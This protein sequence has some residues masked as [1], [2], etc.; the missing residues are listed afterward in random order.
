MRPRLPVGAVAVLVAVAAGI[1]GAAGSVQGRVITDLGTAGGSS[2]KAVA[3][4]PE[5]P[6]VR[7]GAVEPKDAPVRSPGSLVEVGVTSRSALAGSQFRAAAISFT[8]SVV[9]IRDMALLSPPSP[10]PSGITYR[11]DFNEFVISDGEVEETVSGITHFSGSNIW[12]LRLDGTIIRTTNISR[13]APTAVSMTNEPTGMAWNPANGHYYV[14][15]DDAQRVYDLNPGADQQIGTSDDSF[16]SFGTATTGNGDPEGVTIDSASNWVVVSDGVNAEVYIYTLSGTPVSHFDVAQYGI[17]DPESVEFNAANGT[18]FVLGGDKTP[19]IVETT[20]AGAL[21]Q[22]IDISSANVQAPAGLAYAPASNGSGL[23]RFYVVAR[24]VDN[25]SDP[26]IVD[27]KLFELTAVTQ[28]APG[29]L[30]EVH[31]TFTGATS[32]VFDWRGFAA[33]IRYGL[34]SG[35]GSSATASDPSPVPFSSGGPF[36]EVS[37]TG[38]APGTTYHYSIGGG[39]D[40]TF[41]TV[42]TGGFRFDV[43]GDVGSSVMT[44]RAPIVAGEVAADNPAFV[45]VP[46]DISYANSVGQASVDAHFNEVMAWSRSAAYMPAWGNHEWDTPALDDL[47]NYTG[48]FA[49]PNAQ[50]ATGAPAAGCCGE[51][52]SWFDA[53]G[54]RFISYPEPYTGATWTAWRSSVGPIM[55]AAQADPSI[56]YIVTFGHRPAYSTGYH[57]GDATLASILD[58]LGDTYAKYVLNLNG[59]SHNYER[60]Q[61]IHRVTHITAGASTTLETPWA[62][63]D[64]RTAFRALHLSRLRVDVSSSS[65]RIDAICGPTTP[66]EDITCV[67]GTVIDTCTIGVPPVPPVNQAPVVDVGS[68]QAV[69]LPA[70]AM[71]DGTVTDDGLPAPPGAMTTAWSKASG[72]GTVTFANAAAVD[73]SASFSQAGS[74]TLRLTASDGALSSVDTLVVTVTSAPPGGGGGGGGGAAGVPDLRVLLSASTTTPPLGGESDLVATVSNG[75]TQTSMGTHLLITLPS[76]MALLGPPAFERGSGCSGSQSIDCNLDFLPVGV[77]TRVIFAVRVNGQGAIT[78]LASGDKETNPADNTATVTLGPPQQPSTPPVVPAAPLRPVLGKAVTGPLWPLA[79]KRFT[80]TLPV[81]GSDTGA[82]LR[83]GRMVCDPSVAGRVIR[84]AESFTAGKARLSFV[85]PKTAKGKLL[86]VKI[87]ITSSGQATTR[88]FTY[89]V[90]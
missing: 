34:T 5:G 58:T 53:G 62:G 52:W 50:A 66:G 10:D 74:Y 78:V 12:E 38:L 19:I 59:H 60:Y 48:R 89:K 81:K 16:V 49:L 68:D 27:G 1:S 25:N 75:G 31:Y 51:D 28:A 3:I 55:A 72:P 57:N 67:D 83:T 4:N 90:R 36:R 37:L 61:P 47:R 86:K 6:I 18:L 77:T 26:Q 69:T 8:S 39:A 40:H 84:H 17:T 88:L 9:A 46:G 11:P 43:I 56:H 2:G 22:T 85:V 44:S 79:G 14:T 23:M 70:A 35:Y 29:D 82:P 80:F 87:K 73:T 30:D 32:V 7:H 21:V 20:V 13:V 71:L 24:G 33:G 76:T 15:D 41:S 42:P 64:A 65:I 63:T 54:V 45:L